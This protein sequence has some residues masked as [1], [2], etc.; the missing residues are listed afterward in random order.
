MDFGT[1][2]GILLHD[3]L[4]KARNRCFV[5]YETRTYK[6]VFREGYVN[7]KSTPFVILRSNEVQ[8]H[9]TW[10]EALKSRNCLV[11]FVVT[12]VRLAKM[13]QTLYAVLDSE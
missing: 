3:I 6:K 13:K 7:L 10:D 4:K 5:F 1:F 2:L 9:L 11:S 8:V 12:Q